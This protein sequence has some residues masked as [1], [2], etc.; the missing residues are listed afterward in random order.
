[1][2]QTLE[3]PIGP[4]VSPIARLI[5]TRLADYLREIDAPTELLVPRLTAFP[6]TQGEPRLERRR[7]ELAVGWGL[8]VAQPAAAAFL[9]QAITHAV[10]LT[11]AGRDVSRE[12]RMARHVLALHTPQADLHAVRYVFAGIFTAF[13]LGCTGPLQ[14]PVSAILRSGLELL[15]RVLIATPTADPVVT[16]LSDWTPVERFQDFAPRE[17]A[18]A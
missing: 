3:I 13:T 14:W 12:F 1:M 2:G 4:A 18:R 11:R 6:W 10:H 17:A 8:T 7:A 9:N 5:A 16:R 15:D